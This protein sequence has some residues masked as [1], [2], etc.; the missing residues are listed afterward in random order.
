LDSFS[1]STAPNEFIE[2][3]R[4]RL[5][6]FRSRDL[7][8]QRLKPAAVLLLLYP[9]A[10]DL[11]ILLT[12]RTEIV[13]HHKGQICLPGGAVHAADPDLAATALR[14]TYEEVG[15]DP[16]AVE[17]IGRL[18]DLRTVSDFRITP[19][20]GV[21]QQTPTVFLPNPIEVAELLEVPLAHLNDPANAL[22]ERSERGGRVRGWTAY[23]FGEHRIWGAT[24]RMLNEFL[25][26]LR[27]ETEVTDGRAE[28]IDR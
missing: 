1:V 8:L 7:E 26:L 10:G 11:C 4:R 23:T 27:D 13:E 16:N 15:V 14:E 2:H 5:A 22:D 28:R 25:D 20:V 9:R 18:N 12:R 6:A 21:M 3:A 24:A 19:F 17:I